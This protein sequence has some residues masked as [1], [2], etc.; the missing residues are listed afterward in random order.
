MEKQTRRSRHAAAGRGRDGR[1]VDPSREE[2]I[3]IARA[4]M[5]STTE[6]LAAHV[7]ALPDHRAAL[8]DTPPVQDFERLSV[9]LRTVIKWYDDK[10][11]RRPDLAPDVADGTASGTEALEQLVPRYIAMRAEWESREAQ[12]LA[13]DMNTRL[14]RTTEAMRQADVVADQR[15]TPSRASRRRALLVDDVSDILVTVGAF[16]DGIGFDVLR[17]SNGDTALELLAD[18]ARVDLLVT[19]HAMPGMAGGDLVVEAC[20]RNPGLRALIIT[21][22]P[23]AAALA[24]LPPGV[25]LLAKPFRRADLVDRVRSLFE[26]ADATA[27]GVNFVRNV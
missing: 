13:S 1:W 19:D 6:Q 20:Q 7:G 12:L 2:Y 27:A 18:G 11:G 24:I 9:A 10:L 15:A 3:R 21:G 16:L 5:G 23:D 8:G 22:F 17:A 14:Q 25:T 4:L 26:T